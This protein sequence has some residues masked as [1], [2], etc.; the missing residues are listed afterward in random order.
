ME[1]MNRF[2]AISEENT[3]NTEISWFSHSSETSFSLLLI[4]KG[5][6]RIQVLV[7]L[8]D[9]GQRNG[10]SERWYLT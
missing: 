10:A 3:I 8:I 9:V 5:R 6:D 1:W 4:L 2:L 7:L